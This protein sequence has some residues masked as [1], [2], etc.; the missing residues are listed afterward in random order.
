MIG[1]ESKITPSVVYDF[2]PH[3]LPPEYLRAI[4]LVVAS[5]AQTEHVLQDF[6]GGLLG[7]D[8]IQSIALATHMNNPLKDNIIRTLA[9]I[10]APTIKELDKIDELLDAVNAALDK[11]N[12]I[13][14]NPLMTHPDTGEVFSHILNAR[15]AIK[16]ELKRILSSEIEQ[17]A[18]DIYKSGMNIMEFMI[19]RNLFPKDR[20]KPM[21]EPIKR[22]KKARTERQNN[23]KFNKK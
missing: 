8:S 1:S 17:A 10:D 14:H 15:G 6:I 16:L 21:R 12:I 11:R 5:S 3:N 2:D 7:I 18:E 13:V 23:N 20:I 9:E 22:G 4:G 19:T